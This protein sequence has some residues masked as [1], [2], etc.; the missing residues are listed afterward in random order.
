MAKMFSFHPAD[1]AEQ[2]AR[3][4][5]VHIRGGLT[6]EFRAMLTAQVERYLRG[7]L[8][9][10]YAIG[11]KQQAQY[12]FPDDDN[13]LDQL[14]EGVGGVCGLEA[15][16]MILSERHIKTYDDNAD[17]CPLAHK[18]RFASEITVGIPVHV[19]T[20][21]TLILYPDD[22]LDLNPFASSTEMRT[23]LTPDRYPEAALDRARRV[24]LRTEP[25]DIVMF[26][27]HRIWHMRWHAA[28]TASLFLKLNTF[29]CDPLGEDPRHDEMRSRSDAALALTDRELE[30]W[31]PM[32]GS[33]VDCVQRRYDRFWRETVGVTCYR[34]NQITIDESEL[35]ALR[36]MNGRNSV[37]ALI[38]NLG[39]RFSLQ[40]LRRLAAAGVVD[41]LP[42][43]ESPAVG[44][45]SNVVE[46]PIAVRR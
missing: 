13:Y 43:E 45:V 16:K 5:F 46:D 14:F 27:G 28:G 31:T 21:S 20:T 44:R 32:L 7:P 24:E 33:R 8:M 36:C 42:R 37:A 6:R 2:F 10:D 34:G 3:Q 19:P 23:S 9:D 17:P 38:T 15:G 11:D 39:W 1:F 40:S 26:L 18:D 22:E 35:A 12:Q 25:G 30:D 4:R 29:H 41:L